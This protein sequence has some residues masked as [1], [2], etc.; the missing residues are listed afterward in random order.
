MAKKIG[1]PKV[2]IIKSLVTKIKVGINA[3]VFKNPLSGVGKRL[4]NLLKELSTPEY[5]FE[6]I[7]FTPVRIAVPK[8][9][10]HLQVVVGKIRIESLWLHLELPSLLKKYQIEVFDAQWGGGLPFYWKKPTCQMITTFH[11]VLP[12]DFPEGHS[13]LQKKAFESRLRNNLNYAD[14][15][16]TVSDWS[17]SRLKH[18]FP[19]VATKLK[20]FP[21][22]VDQAFVPRTQGPEFVDKDLD[23]ILYLGGFNQR[24]NVERLFE[25][26]KELGPQ[27]PKL[28]LVGKINAYATKNLLPLVNRYQLGEQVQFLGYVSE[29]EL[30]ARLQHGKALIY[31][32]LQEGFG[33][34][35]L[36]AMACGLPV[37]AHNGGATLELVK[38]YPFKV[39]MTHLAEI[40]KGFESLVADTALRDQAVKKGLS[41]AE[42]FRWKTIAKNYAECYSLGNRA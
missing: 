40:K 10:A 20:I 33:M 15:V 34:P 3:T 35:V 14:V 39:P 32:S 25:L 1:K 19:Y 12:L 8:E 38:D 28:H 37:L 36:E 23:A 41:I 9:L 27:A 22:G 5:P 16:V 17:A 29:K 18:Y 2:S 31:P 13:W 4:F 7:L 6:F 26:W 42:S 11:D 24:K 30:I 21:N